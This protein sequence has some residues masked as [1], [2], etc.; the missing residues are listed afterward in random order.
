MSDALLLL[1][2]FALIV[3][4]WGLCR[5][6]AL[7]RPVWEGAE[8]LVYYLLFPA[9]LFS[10]ILRYPL[11][12]GALLSLAGAGVAVTVVGVAAVLCP[13]AVAGRRRAAARLWRA[14]G[15]PLQLLCRTGAGRAPGGHAGRG[16]D[17]AADRVVRATGQRGRGVAAGPPWRPGHGPRTGAQPV[18]RQ[19]RWP[20]WPA[21]CSV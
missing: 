19:H 14:D 9:L 10:S 1:P 15:L 2:D 12:P 6:T 4:G 3:C 5:Y 18:D 20:A 13:A 21:T 17:G 8:K 11:Q 16:L 7:G